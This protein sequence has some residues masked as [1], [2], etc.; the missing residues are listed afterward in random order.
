[1]RVRGWYMPGTMSCS[2]SDI[3]WP[4]SCVGFSRASPPSRTL[5][6]SSAS[7]PRPRPLGFFVTIAQSVFHQVLQQDVAFGPAGQAGVGV[8][9]AA[10]AVVHELRMPGMR[11]QPDALEGAIRVVAA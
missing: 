4:A 5:G 2:I 9:V 11:E 6:P 8:D 1:M 10:L 7:R 3:G